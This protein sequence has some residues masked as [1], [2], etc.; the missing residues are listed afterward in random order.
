[1]SKVSTFTGSPSWPGLSGGSGR[2]TALNIEV[3]HELG[4]SADDLTLQETRVVPASLR[5][6]TIN[7]KSTVLTSGALR[8]R[9]PA[10]MATVRRRRAQSITQQIVDLARH[11][12]ADDF[13]VYTFSVVDALREAILVLLDA[14]SEGNAR[15]VF[16]V[17]RD[18]FL[19]GGWNLYRTA[20]ARDA[21]IGILKDVTVAED[22]SP[23]LADCTFTRL[24]DA[25]LNSIGLTFSD[26]QAEVLS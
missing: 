2:G 24:A 14:E 8:L 19:N 5:P 16:R 1:M 26:G 13:S 17:I 11:A 7:F 21:A 25:G 3:T 18:T 10:Y 9:S 20:I 12:E 4:S 23:E 22:V 6:T 15:E